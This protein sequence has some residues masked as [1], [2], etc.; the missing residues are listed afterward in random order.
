MTQDSVIAAAT[1]VVRVRTEVAAVAKVF[2]Y[3]VPDAWEQP[4]LVGTRVRAP[5]HGR[6]VRGWVV[7]DAVEEPGPCLGGQIQPD[8]VEG[9][10]QSTRVLAKSPQHAGLS[11]ACDEESDEIGGVVQEVERALVGVLAIF[12]GRDGVEH[13]EVGGTLPKIRTEANLAHVLAQ[14]AM[15]AD[16]NS[17]LSGL[18]A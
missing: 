2:D 13:L 17:D 4:V 5:L 9:L 7:D 11:T 6:S 15:I 14:I 16:E 3:A 10:G 1:R 12:E 18:L 8:H